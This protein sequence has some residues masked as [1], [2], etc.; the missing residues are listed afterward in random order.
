LEQTRHVGV[1]KSEH[2]RLTNG[3][4]IFEEFQHMWS[5]FANVT[6]RQTDRRHAIAIPRFAL[7]SI[8][9][10]Y[11]AKGAAVVVMQ[12]LGV[13]LSLSSWHIWPLNLVQNAGR[14]IQFALRV[15]M[16]SQEYNS[17]RTRSSWHY[18]YVMRQWQLRCS[19]KQCKR[20]V[21]MCGK[22]SIWYYLV[23]SYRLH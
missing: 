14:V 21:E 17:S 12:L 8:V 1:A 23:K 18:I 20:H 9:N 3:E 22:Y 11:S 19:L 5:Q 13:R 16:F 10:L 6:D 7:T 4:I 15:A 2:P